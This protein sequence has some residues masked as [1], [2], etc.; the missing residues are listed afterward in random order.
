MNIEYLDTLPEIENKYQVELEDG[1]KVV[2]TAKLSTFGTETD[3]RL[4]AESYF[5]LTNKSIIAD[6]GV[7]TW[8]VDI[9]EDVV[10]CCEERSSL[11]FFRFP[12]IYLALNTEIVF[13]GGKGK[14]TGFHFYFNKKDRATFLN[15]MNTVLN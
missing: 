5:T 2:F 7:G 11:V 9:V 12:Y 3:S 6:N 15:I 1:E 4:G 13:D 14:L 10:S 8:T